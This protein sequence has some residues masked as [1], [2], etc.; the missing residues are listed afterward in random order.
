MLHLHEEEV[1]E[2]E[3]MLHDLFV[4]RQPH[5]VIHEGHIHEA[6][7]QHIDNP[8]RW[9]QDERPFQ[10]EGKT[11]REPLLKGSGSRI[12]HGENGT[13]LNQGRWREKE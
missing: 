6:L 5:I 2:L 1:G 10:K 11:G 12:G 4:K 8:Q 13:K 7:V 3:F 9:G